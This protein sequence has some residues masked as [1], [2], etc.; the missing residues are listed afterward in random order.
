MQNF[1]AD[2]PHFGE[3]LGEI[4]ILTTHNLLWQ[5][6]G[7]FFLENCS[8]MYCILSLF[9]LCHCVRTM[10]VDLSQVPRCIDRIKQ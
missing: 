10:S 7:A 3:I 2:K 8:F 5:E 4:E 6:F 1:G 9:F